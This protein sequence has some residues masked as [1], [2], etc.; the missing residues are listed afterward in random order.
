MIRKQ[1]QVCGRGQGTGN[2]QFLS[3]HRKRRK[4]LNGKTAVKTVKIIELNNKKF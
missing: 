3:T 4:N 1:V 2:K